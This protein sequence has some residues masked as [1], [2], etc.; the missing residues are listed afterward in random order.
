MD[1][2]IAANHEDK[3]STMAGFDI[4][5]IG[6][7]L[8]YIVRGE[9]KFKNL[10]KKKTS[11]GMSVTFLGENVVTGFKVEVHI[12]LGRQYSIIR[13]AST[14]RFQTDSAYGA[15]IEIQQQELDY[16]IGQEY[17]Y[18]V[19]SSVCVVDCSTGG[20]SMSLKTCIGSMF[21]A[22]RGVGSVI[23]IRCD[24]LLVAGAVG[25]SLS[26][27]PDIIGFPLTKLYVRGLSSVGKDPVRCSRE[28]INRQGYHKE[29]EEDLALVDLDGVVELTG[30]ADSKT[31]WLSAH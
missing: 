30:L 22:S 24:M 7:Q 11:A 6:K 12:A 15:N 18:A 17:M 10:K 9:T 20:L 31:V 23:N 2:S 26:T 3:A 21:V 16:H 19:Q 4:Q 8:A 25:Q 29:F 1:S 28:K 13:S 5:P 14:V 27:R